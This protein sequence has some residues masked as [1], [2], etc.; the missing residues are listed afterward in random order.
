MQFPVCVGMPFCPEHLP[1]WVFMEG[2]AKRHLGQPSP[3][4]LPCS[5]AQQ[6]A[7][8]SH[9]G[10]P[11]T[12]D[13]PQVLVPA[14]LEHPTPL[15]PSQSTLCPPELEPQPCSTAPRI[16]QAA[17]TV[18]GSKLPWPHSGAPRNILRHC[19]LVLFRVPQAPGYPV[20][21]GC[22]ALLCPGQGFI[23]RVPHPGCSGASQHPRHRRHRHPSTPAR[24]VGTHPGPE[25]EPGP[26]LAPRVVPGSAG[27]VTKRGRGGAAAN[28]GQWRPRHRRLPGVPQGG[29]G[30][31]GRAEPQPQPG[32][33]GRSGA[34]RGGAER[35]NA[36]GPGRGVRAPPALGQLPRAPP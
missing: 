16:P 35:G 5:G 13:G 15:S 8:H 31:P 26:P 3:T 9:S 21:S 19:T 14:T 28:G 36:R 12:A 30:G 17:R 6:P 29:R 34:E 32:R 22:R 33:P 10:E 24:G 7:P 27:S 25:P 23:S 20:P 11:Q 1:W 4:S 18:G 2:E